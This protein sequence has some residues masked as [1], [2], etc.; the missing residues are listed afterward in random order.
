MNSST[1]GVTGCAMMRDTAAAAA[2]HV[3]IHGA[4]GAHRFRLRREFEGGFGDDGEGTFGAD[5]QAR[6]V[7]THGALG[8]VNAGREFLAGPVTARSPSTLSRAV[9]YFTLLGPPAPQAR[10]PPTVE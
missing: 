5:D 8:G 4:Q 10:L 2:G 7:V 6:E 9:P 3:R 1:Q